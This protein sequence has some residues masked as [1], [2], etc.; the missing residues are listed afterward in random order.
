MRK[1]DGKETVNKEQ[2]E[3]SSLVEDDIEYQEEEENLDAEEE[4]SEPEEEEDLNLAYISLI[5]KTEH[6]LHEDHRDLILKSIKTVQE[7]S[8]YAARANLAR[9]QEYWLGEESS[10][11]FQEQA[12]LGVR[13]NLALLSY[14]EAQYLINEG[15]ESDLIEA[16]DYY[17]EAKTNL[18]A[19]FKRIKLSDPAVAT[20]IESLTKD[21]NSE[22]KLLND[23]ISS[24]EGSRRDGE[25]SEDF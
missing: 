21:I 15:K 13:F 14:L 11:E 8:F 18:R 3:L 25:N 16:K 10:E 20:H 17:M 6:F 9:A 22:I 19:V 12:K 23:K 2:E 7:N 1:K 5:Q 4:D 24:N